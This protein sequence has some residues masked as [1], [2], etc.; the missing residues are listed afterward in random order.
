V[1]RLPDVAEVLSPL[2]YLLPAQLM[3]YHLAMA[4]FADAET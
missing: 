2:L 4:K 1:V 3:G